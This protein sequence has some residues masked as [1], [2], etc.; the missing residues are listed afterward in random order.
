MT[1]LLSITNTFILGLS[2][3]G[4]GAWGGLKVEGLEKALLAQVCTAYSTPR[5][6]KST[7]PN[8][9]KTSWC[10][11]Q[12]AWSDWEREAQVGRLWPP[13]SSSCL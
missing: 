12:A 10:G 8:I 5:C 7:L 3:G 11:A 4:G 2:A 6:V 1:S 9:L 13:T